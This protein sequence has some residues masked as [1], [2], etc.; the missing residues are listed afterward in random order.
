MRDASAGPARLAAIRADK[1]SCN[2]PQTGTVQDIGQVTVIECKLKDA[3]VAYRAYEVRKGRM[4]YEA[5]GL[6]GYDSA[7]QLGLRSLVAD[8]PIAVDAEGK[9]LSGFLRVMGAP[10]DRNLVSFYFDTGL[11]YKGPFGRSRARFRSPRRAPATP[12]RS[13]AS[14]PERSTQAARSPK[15]IAATIRAITPRPPNFSPRS[16]VRAMH[17]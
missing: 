14:R 3:E 16:A 15:R 13:L 5:E 8:Q 17:R 4:L 2:A 1:M 9:G 7:I 6:A 11:A 10:G 12:P